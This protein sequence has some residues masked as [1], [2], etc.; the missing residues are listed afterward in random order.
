MHSLYFR[1]QVYG[2]LSFVELLRNPVHA[3]IELLLE[4]V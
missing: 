2:F 1:F 4:Y 3:L